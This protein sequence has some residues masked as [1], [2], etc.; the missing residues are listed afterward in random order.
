MHNFQG[1]RESCNLRK[2]KG[3]IGYQLLNVNGSHVGT[4]LCVLFFV[5]FCFVFLYA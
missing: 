1:P 3:Y 5:Q 2:I 4:K